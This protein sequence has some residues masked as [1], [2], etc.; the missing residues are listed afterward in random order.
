[1]GNSVGVADK[2]PEVQ[3]ESNEDSGRIGS[4]DE[5]SSL[6]VI[7][8]LIVMGLFGIQQALKN[9][10]QEAVMRAHATCIEAQADC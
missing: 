6:I 8:F 7:L 9:N 2:E 3:Q 4:W 10:Q 5:A 1:M